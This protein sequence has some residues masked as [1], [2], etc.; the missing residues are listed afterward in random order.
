LIVHH[1]A[2]AESGGALLSPESI[3]SAD[4]P[5]KMVGSMLIIQAESLAA[6][7]KRIESDIYWTSN[8]VSIIVS[9]DT[10]NIKHAS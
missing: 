5:Q 4:A 6:A 3:E 9:L 2:V 8:V 10:S 7:S 1:V